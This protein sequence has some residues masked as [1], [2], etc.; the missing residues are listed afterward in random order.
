MKIRVMGIKSFLTETLFG[1]FFFTKGMSVYM[2]QTLHLIFFYWENI[3]N[4][5]IRLSFLVYSTNLSKACVLV[6]KTFISISREY[7]YF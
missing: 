4:F 6:I 3:G 7:V 5:L 1:R 2:Q